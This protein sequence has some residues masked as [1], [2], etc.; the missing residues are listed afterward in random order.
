MEKERA[1]AERALHIIMQGKGGVGKSTVARFLAEFLLDHGAPPT[2]FDLDAVN[3]SF[4]A[5]KAL[6]ATASDIMD[7]DLIDPRKFDAV[8]EAVLGTSD[9][10]VIDCG[11]STFNPMLAYIDEIDLFAVL[12]DAGFNVHLH[13][14]ISGGADLQDTVQGFATLAKRF[15]GA[16]QLVVWLNPKNGPIEM[17]GKPFEKW[18]VTRD[19]HEHLKGFVSLPVLGPRTAAVD[20]TEMLSKGLIFGEAIAGESPLPVMAR[21]RLRRVRDTIFSDIDTVLDMQTMPK[22][23]AAE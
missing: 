3:P 14:V 17:A 22:I 2:C 1:G 15:G 11:A 7:G 10:V 12:G 5:V 6:K 23:E 19:N 9:A 21:H 18:P 16:A 8:V 13:T 4:S 20:L